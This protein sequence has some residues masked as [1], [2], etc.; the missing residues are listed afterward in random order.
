MSIGPSSLVTSSCA[1]P[2]TRVI[3]L[4]G[5]SADPVAELTGSRDFQHEISFSEQTWTL[6]LDHNGMVDIEI[7][8]VL[9]CP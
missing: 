3:S 4:A 1:L 5:L 2:S 6:S 7:P 8:V 9:E